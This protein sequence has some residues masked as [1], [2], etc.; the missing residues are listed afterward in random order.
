MSLQYFTDQG[1][2]LVGSVKTLG[3]IPGAV[4]FTLNNI[5]DLDSRLTTKTKKP[6]T[7]FW[8]PYKPIK[9]AFETPLIPPDSKLLP[10]KLFDTAL[11]VL[12]DPGLVTSQVRKLKPFVSVVG[13]GADSI[14]DP[15]RGI[16]QQ[17]NWSGLTRMAGNVYSHGQK[18]RKRRGW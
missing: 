11:K 3:P 4:A 6:D 16:G 2:K 9:G 7:P 13:S 5:R 17:P 1:E 8:N 12:D 14:A 10:G 15:F 18:I